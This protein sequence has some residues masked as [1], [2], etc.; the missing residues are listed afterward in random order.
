MNQY[1]LDAP[2]ADEYDNIKITD[3]L[4][5]ST[6]SKSDMEKK[7]MKV[8]VKVIN[9]WL[10]NNKTLAPTST[11]SNNTYLTELVHHKTS[12]RVKLSFYNNNRIRMIFI[13]RWIRKM[14]RSRL[15]VLNIKMLMETLTFRSV[16]TT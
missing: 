14:I 11:R 16:Q 8:M 4:K 12:R 1:E 13:L 10:S 2:E 9:N 5:S 7:T 3:P 6:I 15:L